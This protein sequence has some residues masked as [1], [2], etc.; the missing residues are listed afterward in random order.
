MEKKNLEPTIENRKARHGF[1]IFET[2]EA[3]LVLEGSEVKSI[4][5]SL[6]SIAEGF[7]HVLKNQAWLEGVHINTYT[8]RSTHTPEKPV[9]SIKL[10]LHQ[11]EIFKIAQEM[12]LKK[13][14]GIPLKIYFVKGKAKVLFGLARGKKAS[15][16]RESI[17]K[18]DIEKNLR[19]QF[20][21]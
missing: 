11:R 12:K 3:G 15:D 10:L 9:R 20:R 8:H 19:K 6:I 18:R 7:V 4:R 21:N 2:F 17:K 5:Y 13:M 1:E 14:T 16:K